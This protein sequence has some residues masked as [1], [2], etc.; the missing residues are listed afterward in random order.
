MSAKLS[1]IEQ[2]KL[3]DIRAKL[4]RHFD[5]STLKGHGLKEHVA[6]EF[7]LML[8]PDRKNRNR[9]YT[10]ASIHIKIFFLLAADILM[11]EGDKSL[12]FN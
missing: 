12:I 2:D 5:I 7:Y 6:Q 8:L 9:Q 4:Y 3:K 10:Y 11:E 1:K